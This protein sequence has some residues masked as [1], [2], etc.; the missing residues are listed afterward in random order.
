MIPSISWHSERPKA[1]GNTFFMLVEGKV[2]LVVLAR[3]GAW[4]SLLSLFQIFIM[5]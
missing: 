2:Q 1:P 5:I 3:L 4:H